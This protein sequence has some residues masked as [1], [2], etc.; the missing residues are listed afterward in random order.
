[1]KSNKLEQRIAKKVVPYTKEQQLK[2]KSSIS[3]LI[4]ITCLEI[5]TYFV[6]S[7]EKISVPKR[8]SNV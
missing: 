2:N 8:G 6:L 4:G 1:M 7:P 5:K 3:H